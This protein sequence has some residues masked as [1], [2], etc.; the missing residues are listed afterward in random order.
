MLSNIF[1]DSNGEL[2]WS[3]VSATVSALSAFLV[4][5]GVIMN[6]RTQ[7][8]IAKQQIDANLKAKARIKWIGGVRDKTSE[9]ISLLLSLQKEKTVFYK[10]WLE[11]EEVSELLK[12]YF[13]SKMN[14]KSNSEIYIDK[15]K[16]IISKSA[17]FI[18]FKETDNIN[19]H[20]YIK[21]YIECLVELYKED[22]Y[23]KIVSEIRFYSDLINKLYE[24]NFEYTLSHEASD[25]M[26]IKNTPAEK[27]EGKAYDYAAAENNIT[28]YQ[29]EIKKL[30]SR[31]I[32]YQKSIEDFSLIISLYL[33]IEWDKAK[34]GK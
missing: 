16:I 27:L 3:G 33:K 30:K 23:Q 14:E 12:L 26:E 19:K 8:K 7:R 22:N 18:V 28:H 17:R 6:V 34:E 2:I 11:I 1:I 13:N 4:F 9:L 5:I 29:E 32:D 21:R 15:N 10:Q 25:L 31:L 24:E 20:A